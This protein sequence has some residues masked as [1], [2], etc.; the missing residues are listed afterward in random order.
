MGKSDEHQQTKQRA[1]EG[2]LR[3]SRWCD[4]FRQ[5]CEYKMQFGD[6]IVSRQT[7]DNRKLGR[8]VSE[9][10]TQYRK[11]TQGTPN[12][13]TPERIRA[14]D[15]IGFNWGSS[16]SERFR[17]LC[18]FRAQF[19]HCLVPNKCPVNPKLGQWVVSQRTFYR[20][21]HEDKPSPMTEERI[22]TLQSVG[23]VWN[24]TAA[25]W[26]EKFAQLIEFKA[27]F[28]HFVVPQ[29]YPAN[30]ELGGWVK[31]QHIYCKSYQEGNTCRQMAVRIRELESI[32]F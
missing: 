25:F 11:H 12:T 9:Q 23:F 5:L 15:G 29:Q 17:D 27:Q 18:E 21:Y 3:H 31:Q 30:P 10:R 13:I 1:H 2:G 28:G 7:S 16:W 6:C 24:T 32:G 26:N 14:L 8:W 20:L 4:F 19:G 22:R